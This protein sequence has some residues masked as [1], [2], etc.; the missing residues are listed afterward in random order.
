MS[1]NTSQI[2]E[3]QKNRTQNKTIHPVKTTTSYGNEPLCLY[4]LVYLISSSGRF[5]EQWVVTS[6]DKGITLST[7]DFQ[8]QTT[9]R[10]IERLGIKFR[11][12][13]AANGIPVFA[14]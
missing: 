3:T 1:S 13:T 11:P 12:V 14:Y 7:L 8:K 10:D 9:V 5:P 2:E 4:Q 6:L